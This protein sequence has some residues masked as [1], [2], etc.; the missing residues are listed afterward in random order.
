MLTAK[1]IEWVIKTA[2]FNAE[3]MEDA[4]RQLRYY[5]AKF[6]EVTIKDGIYGIL[7]PIEDGPN[8]QF[9]A[10][11]HEQAKQEIVEL[12]HGFLAGG[13][14]VV[15]KTVEKLKQRFH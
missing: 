4:D 11:I 9:C 6:D 5:W 3:K 2:R 12:L 7:N 10:I 14:F 8:R 13:H 1:L 15:Q